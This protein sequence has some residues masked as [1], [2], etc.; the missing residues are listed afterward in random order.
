MNLSK[1]KNGILFTS[2]VLF[3]TSCNSTVNRFDAAKED[4]IDSRKDFVKAQDEHKVE[5][6]NFRN[7]SNKVILQN[8]QKISDFKA[9]EKNTKHSIRVEEEK[10]YDALKEKNIALKSRLDEFKDTS[11]EN[12]DSF[13]VEFSRDMESFGTSIKDFTRIND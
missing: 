7:T 8:E 13:R 1:L 2:T 11:K 9:R 6:A 3:L 4:V 10:Q 12:W 5:L